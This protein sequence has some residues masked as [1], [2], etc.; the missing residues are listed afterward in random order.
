MI[1]YSKVQDWVWVGLFEL[2]AFLK[3][4]GDTVNAPIERHL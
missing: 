3:F 4:F 2:L 1:F